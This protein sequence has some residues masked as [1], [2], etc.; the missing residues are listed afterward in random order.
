MKIFWKTSDP[1]QAE[2][3]DE[4]ASRCPDAVVK[5][6]THVGVDW[7]HPSM[8][9]YRLSPSKKIRARKV[10]I[11]PDARHD[12]QQSTTAKRTLSPEQETEVKRRL[13]ICA[14][15]DDYE[16]MRDSRTVK[17]AR[18][19]SACGCRSLTGMCSKWD[20]RQA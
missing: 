3:F 15:C 1:A 16:G 19:T 14:K 10:I 9:K 20:I 2:K 4:L 11:L 13:S 8:E 17:C 12:E 18:V 6:G 7:D 5:E